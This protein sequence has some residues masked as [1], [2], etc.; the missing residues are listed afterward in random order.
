MATKQ[1]RSY[2]A[3]ITVADHDIEQTGDHAV[4]GLETA[5]DASHTADSTSSSPM[6]IKDTD[7]AL[8]S[9]VLHGSN[10][11]HHNVDATAT[12]PS[13][14]A[15]MTK[16]LIGGGVL[17]LRCVQQPMKNLC[18]CEVIPLFVSL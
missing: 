9:P 10:H 11:L 3:I 17:S 18:V 7:A 5:Y 1:Q 8:R 14:V 6:L 4:A 15:N 2:G 13:E 16:N 12:I